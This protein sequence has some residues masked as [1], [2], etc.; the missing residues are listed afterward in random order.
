MVEKLF[1]DDINPSDELYRIIRDEERCIKYKSYMENLWEIYHPYADRDFPKQ[2]PQD[3]HSRFWE[4]YLTCTLVCN[5]FKVVPK[6]T[7]SQGPDIL[8]DDSL[9]RIFLE[10]I[11]PSEGRNGNPD[12]VPEL[13]PMKAIVVPDIP[14]ILRYSSAIADKYNK[15]NTYLKQG[16]IS[17]SDS[18]II[19]L[20]S[21]KIDSAIFDQTST[22]DFPRIV[23]AVLPIGNKAV[24]ISK[25]SGPIVPWHYQC[26]SNIYRS[27]GSAVSTNL[28]LRPEY[29]NL[30]GILYSRLDIANRPNQMGDDFIF[31]HNPKS[32]QN[33]VPDEY[34]KLGVEYFV[35]LGEKDFSISRKD[36]RQKQTI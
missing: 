35:K 19:A 16:I 3:F 14:I 5:S 17:P 36:W 29:E 13:Q 34:F 31:I 20:N 32:T 28:F 23:K 30:S 6:Q 27:S 1:S 21:C 12:R 18:Y 10:A 15:Y 33:A 24:P 11:A 26:R 2:L 22:N 8:I 4:M 9:Q 7:R 25:L